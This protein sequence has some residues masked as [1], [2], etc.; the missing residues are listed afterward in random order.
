M[1]SLIGIRG[2]VI[3]NKNAWLSI[4]ALAYWQDKFSG[5]P[6]NIEGILWLT[7]KINDSMELYRTFI[8]EYKELV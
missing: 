8:F 5:F 2:G 6:K 7:K 1:K 3:I 4:E